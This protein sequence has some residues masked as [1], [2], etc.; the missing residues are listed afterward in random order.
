MHRAKNTPR[1]ENRGWGLVS[2]AQNATWSS[3]GQAGLPGM[4][5]FAFS[6]DFPA[7]QNKPQWPLRVCAARL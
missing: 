6:A 2:M 3:I 7:Q 1:R 5:V 4:R